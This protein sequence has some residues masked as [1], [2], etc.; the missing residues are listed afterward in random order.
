MPIRCIIFMPRNPVERNFGRSQVLHIRDIRSVE[1]RVGL[2]LL[3]VRDGTVKK[4]V[5]LKSRSAGHLK[6]LYFWRP[7]RHLYI[8]LGQGGLGSQIFDM[9][10]PSA[11][12]AILVTTTTSPVCSSPTCSSAGANSIDSSIPVHRFSCFCEGWWRWKVR[13]PLLLQ[14]HGYLVGIILRL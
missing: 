8:Q 7:Y 10:K 14:W 3:H 5:E 11:W 6:L 4:R 13:R 12:F 2:R 1:V 9:R